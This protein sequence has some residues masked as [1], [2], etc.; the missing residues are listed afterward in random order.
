MADQYWPVTL[1]QLLSETGFSEREGDTLLRSD[2]DVGPKKVRRRFTK[3]I[4]MMTG[5][6]WLTTDQYLDFK[7]FYN[8]TLNGGALP[9]IFPH[10]ITQVPTTFRFSETPNYNS[11]GGGQFAVSFSWEI[12]P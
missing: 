12:M 7:A 5:S 11:L 4:G 10:P 9:F 3:G 8:T 2:M 6:V 1:Q